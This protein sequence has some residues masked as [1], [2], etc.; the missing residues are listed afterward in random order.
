ME[1]IFKIAKFKLEEEQFTKVGY[2]EYQVTYINSKK[3]HLLRIVVNGYPTN[4]MINLVEGT[5]G[6]KSKILLSIKEYL[7][8]GQ[9]ATNLTTKKITLDY[10]KNFYSKRIIHNV[11]NY[12]ININKEESRDRITK[13]GLINI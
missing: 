8:K 7:I 5:S 2:D 13:F 4:Q 11:E 1:T 9:Y 3:V 12:L 6:Y 10:L